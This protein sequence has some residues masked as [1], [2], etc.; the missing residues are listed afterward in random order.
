MNWR[1]PYIGRSGAAFLLLTFGSAECTAG[2]F[3]AETIRVA[4]T[5]ADDFNATN[6]WVSY[7]VDW[8][9][10]AISQSALQTARA[11]V[12][13]LFGSSKEVSNPRDEFTVMR[14]EFMA[15][16]GNCHQGAPVPP[17]RYFQRRGARITLQ[18]E[19]VIQYTMEWDGFLGGN[20][21]NSDTSYLL[22]D[23]RTG[24]AIGISE[25]FKARKTNELSRRIEARIQKVREFQSAEEMKRNF[26]Q[27]K[28]VTAQNIYL[29]P[30]RIGFHYNPYA[31][32]CYAA[33]PTDAEFDI[34]E[35][36]DLLR[37]GVRE[38]LPPK[39]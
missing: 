33:G 11:R 31:I 22:L 9:T 28:R 38:T 25:L 4:T 2:S 30:G 16:F 13:S 21:P 5:H 8:P 15:E 14:D 18:T 34:A 6:S 1:L 7:T 32:A 10:N 36:A 3:Q 20:H 29:L 23:T 39:K 12:W 27:V 17:L 37:D 19:H 24:E 26:L 35:L